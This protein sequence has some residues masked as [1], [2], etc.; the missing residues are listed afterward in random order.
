[1]HPYNQKRRSQYAIY[2]TK[3]GRHCPTKGCM[4][5][6]DP[7]TEGTV[8]EFAQYGVGISCYFKFLKWCIYIYF[9]MSLTAIPAIVFNTLGVGATYTD[10]TGLSAIAFTTVGNLGDQVNSTLITIP[11]C[12]GSFL[13]SLVGGAP[14][15]D[16]AGGDG[17]GEEANPCKLN[18]ERLREIYV[19][20]DTIACVFFLIGH[21]WQV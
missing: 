6:C 20:L 4:S 8:S 21:W 3:T 13:D 5:K 14:L 18:K 2:A 1:M 17:A 9:L 16:D 10:S 11:Y 7:C 19:W 15:D 12:D